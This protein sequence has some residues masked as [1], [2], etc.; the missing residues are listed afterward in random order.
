MRGNP[1][2]VIIMLLILTS[3][4]NG[5]HSVHSAGIR[6]ITVSVNEKNSLSCR[7]TFVTD[8]SVKTAVRYFSKDHTGYETAEDTEGKDHYFFLWGMHPSAD[9]TIEIYDAENMT[10]PLA[11][12]ACRTGPAPVHAP[13]FD[14]TVNDHAKV[15]DGFVLFTYWALASDSTGYSYPIAMMYDT[16]GKMVWYYEFDEFENV[17]IGDLQFTGKS[18]TVLIGLSK[19]ES[20][21]GIPLEEGIEIDLEGNI[22]WRSAKIESAYGDLSS[23]HHTYELLDDGSLSFLGIEV[24]DMTIG[25]MIVNVD[26]GYGLIWSWS[27]FEH[28]TPP[29]YNGT[30]WFDWTHANSVNFDKDNGAV[31]VNSRNLSTYY[32]IAYPEGDIIWKLGENGDFKM[33]TDHSDPWFEFAHD[34]E[35]SGTVPGRILFYDNGSVQK[36]RSRIIEYKIDETE[37]TAE[38]VFEYDGSKTGSEWFT[39]FGGDADRLDNGNIFVTA[40]N[41]GPVLDTRLF[42]ITSAGE[43]V[44]EMKFRKSEDWQ[45]NIYNAQ[46]IETQKLLKRISQ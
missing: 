36:G 28:I 44:W 16:E 3:C 39:E 22:V 46:K 26:S 13:K 1:A 9:Y 41:T 20:L 30:D 31:Y 35:N 2:A 18:G 24:S 40:G 29:E 34:P 38:I 45:I 8:A 43:L 4:G 15:S 27:F 32:K 14:M 11:V 21:S 6:D 33:L 42:E 23:W 10:E 19:W 17:V 37:M 12:S 5:T 7:L 25:D